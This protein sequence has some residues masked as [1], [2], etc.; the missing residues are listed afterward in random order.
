MNYEDF[1]ESIETLTKKIAESV[2]GED[3]EIIAACFL[4]IIAKCCEQNGPIY[5]NVIKRN[6]MKFFEDYKPPDQINSQLHH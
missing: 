1:V 4:V 3:A 5:F 6:Y 2:H